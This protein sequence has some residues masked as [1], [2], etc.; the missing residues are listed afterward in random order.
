M[1]HKWYIFCT[2]YASTGNTLIKLSKLTDYAVVILG[3]MAQNT[4]S[5]RLQT[6]VGLSGVTGLSEPTVAKVLK[7]LAR[8]GVVASTRGVNGGYQLSHEPETI[9]MA[10][11]IVAI[12]GPVLLTSCVEVEEACCCAHS[13]SCSMR[14]KWNPVNEAMKAALESVTLAQM[15]KG[16]Q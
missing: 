4:E 10:S 5:G 3:A 16:K 13:N 15:I 1:T 12:E 11:V 8:S 14:G 9:T 7:M 6:S 2:I